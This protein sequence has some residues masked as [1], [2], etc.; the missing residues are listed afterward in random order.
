MARAVDRLGGIIAGGRPVRV[1][2]LLFPDVEVLDFAGP[3]EVFSVADRVARRDGLVSGGAFDVAT[4]AVGSRDVRARHGLVVCATYDTSDAPPFDLLVVPGGVVTQPLG[5]AATLDYIRRASA[6]ATLTA[7]VCTGA[8]L[9]A[10]I[11]LLEG[12]AATT[13]WED[14]PDLRAA[15]PALRVLEGVP[16]VD[17][18]E[19][20]TAAGISA[21]IGMSL[22][23][24][25]G[26]LGSDAARATARQMQ[27]DWEPAAPAAQD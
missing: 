25:A 8:F 13:H 14:I 21:G 7:S 2:I 9:L 24:V 10:A 3:F 12:R 19:V 26:I 11:G 15:H 1:G 16:F 5:D 4:V 23:L 6:A 22:H 27:Y 17:E 20:I 18:D